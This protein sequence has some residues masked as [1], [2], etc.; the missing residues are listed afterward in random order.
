[1]RV[2]TLLGSAILLFCVAG[3]GDDEVA[4][5]RVQAQSLRGQLPELDRRLTGVQNDTRS[6]RRAQQQQAEVQRLQAQVAALGKQLR[7]IGLEP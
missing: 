5:L 3:C 4:P 6:L 2:F 1:M 7:D